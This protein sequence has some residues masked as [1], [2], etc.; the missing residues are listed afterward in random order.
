VWDEVVGERREFGEI[1]EAAG[2][3]PRPAVA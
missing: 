1:V 3:M 2:L